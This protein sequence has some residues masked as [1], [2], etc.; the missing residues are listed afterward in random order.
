VRAGQFDVKDG[1]IQRIRPASGQFPRRTE[2]HLVYN[3]TR[4]LLSVLSEV[5]STDLSSSILSTFLQ[6]IE[7][8]K[9][10][11]AS[12]RGL[13]LDIDVP[14]RF[15]DRYAQ[16]LKLV[17]R[18]LPSG[19]DVSITG[20]PTWFNSGKLSDVLNQVDFWIPQCYGDKIPQ[21]LSELN[22]ISSTPYVL[23]C[24]QGARN[25][26][27]PYYAGLPAYGYIVLFGKD[28]NLLSLRGDI[29]PTDVAKN[30]DLEVVSTE[31][32]VS[33]LHV[34]GAGYRY[35]F[36]ASRDG[37]LQGLTYHAGEQILVD[38]QSVESLRQLVNIT[39]TSGGR[40]LLGACIFRLPTNDDPSNLNVEQVANA[41]CRESQA[42]HKPQL[43]DIVRGALIQ[44]D[45]PNYL[46]VA[47]ENESIV[48]TRLGDQSLVI[49]LQL[50]PGSLREIRSMSGFE[51]ARTLCQPAE[52]DS[53]REGQA[54]PCSVY[55]ANLVELTTRAWPSRSHGTVL[56]AFS[57]RAPT[58]LSASANVSLETGQLLP[59]NLQLRTAKET[60]DE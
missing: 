10:D 30:L 43:S 44:T 14:T 18:D 28:G 26:G 21:H 53:G 19:M 6:D 54:I 48:G 51:S 4:E 39:L 58:E 12:V 35:I 36:K 27:R 7:R 13:Q 52:R 32:P 1:R 57:D 47:F 49:T 60:K 24:V 33:S 16:L 25:L 31:L 5:D 17:R 38:T 22:S 23:Q 45:Y 56:L 15:L 42:A 46:L 11:G 40:N 50:K 29:D 2:I 55:R 34:E 37:A 41:L 59:L 20:L 8:A 9:D 3:A